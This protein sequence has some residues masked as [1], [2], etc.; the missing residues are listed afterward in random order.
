[1]DCR[2]TNLGLSDTIA[3]ME[4]LFKQ[5]RRQ[6]DPDAKGDPIH[7]DGVNTMEGL[8]GLISKKDPIPVRQ[9]N[10]DDY[11]RFRC[12]EGLQPDH[13]QEVESCLR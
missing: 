7:I 6:D 13:L 8:K 5:K 11:A 1:M 2:R 3:I 10:M 4:K 12:Q 9:A